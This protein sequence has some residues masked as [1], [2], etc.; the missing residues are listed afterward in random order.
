MKITEE[1][2][3]MT[4]TDNE[5]KETIVDAKVITTEDG[6]DENGTPKKSVEIKIPAA[7]AGVIPGEVN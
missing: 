3:K 2:R 7:I 1:D 4:I 6:V 5:G